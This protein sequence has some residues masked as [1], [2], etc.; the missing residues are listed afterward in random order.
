[1]CDIPVGV[2]WSGSNSIG[3]VSNFS[4]ARGYELM[5]T[6]SSTCQSNGTWAGD[7]P[8]CQGNKLMKDFL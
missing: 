6:S 2:M 4:C 7:L 3:G 5:G 1:M 8:S